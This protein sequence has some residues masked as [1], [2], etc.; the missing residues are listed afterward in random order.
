MIAGIVTTY[1]LQLVREGSVTYPDE[2]LTH[3]EK[4]AKLFTDYIGN[5]DREIFV[6]IAVD[7]RNRCIGINTVSVG[8][9]DTAI[10]TAREVFKF[11]ILANAAR[12]FLAHNHPSGDCNP[13][14]SDLKIT[15]DLVN[16]GK[17]FDIEVLDHVITG[18]DGKYYSM[19]TQNQIL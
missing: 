14:G 1:K 2:Q 13:S 15:L 10:V 7:T 17:V 9:I 18:Y 16:A 8:S 5:A 6:V 3:S 11:A 4:V 12:L 19:R